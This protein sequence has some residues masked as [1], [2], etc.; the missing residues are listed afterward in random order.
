[1]HGRLFVS[2][3]DFLSSSKIVFESAVAN[4]AG[5]EKKNL[6]LLGFCNKFDFFFSSGKHFSEFGGSGVMALV[7]NLDHLEKE[8]LSA[9]QLPVCVGMESLIL[10]F[11]T[12]F[13]HFAISEESS[14][15]KAVGILRDVVI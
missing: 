4:F 11:H 10:Q 2:A 3:G 15:S 9:V 12:F 7:G 5:C 13:L 14:H 8:C 1:M 6:A